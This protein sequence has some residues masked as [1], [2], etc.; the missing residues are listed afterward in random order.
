[1]AYIQGDFAERGTIFRPHIYERVGTLPKRFNFLLRKIKVE[2]GCIH[3]KDSVFTARNLLK[4]C[5]YLK[6]I[7]LVRYKPLKMKG[8]PFLSKRYINGK[9]GNMLFENPTATKYL[10]HKTRQ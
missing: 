10:C 4:Y 6:G 2:N 8:V 5:R 3:I 9:R 1:M 7:P